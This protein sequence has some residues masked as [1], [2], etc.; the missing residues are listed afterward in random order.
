MAQINAA[1]LALIKQFENCE[2]TA[3]WDSMGQVWTIGWG[4]T[5]GIQMG[6]RITQAQ[7]DAFLVGDLA[8]AEA[9]VSS[10]ISHDITPNQFSALVSFQYNTGALAGST[11][12]TML[13][14]GNI[15]GA[16]DQ[17]LVWNKGMVDGV[18][19]PISGLTLRRQ[20]ERTLFLT[21]G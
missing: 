18:L 6:D 16:A 8:K 14:G 12:L 5:G 21:P 2:L 13:N 9:Q 17:F 1:G 4:H 3:Y 11:L 19:Q 15:I 7:A 20:A 10:C